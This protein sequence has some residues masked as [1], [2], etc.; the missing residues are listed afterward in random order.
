[1]R[2]LPRSTK[3]IGLALALLLL[4]PT[5]AWTA[6]AEDV[7]AIRPAEYMIYQ[8][9]GVSLVVKIDADEV[10]FESRITGPESALI[11]DSAVP[12]RR[13]GPMFQFIGSSDIPR[14]LM[15]KVT[16]G[17]RIDRSRIGMELIQLSGRDSNSQALAQAYELFSSGTERIHARDKGSWASKAYSLKGAA[18]AFAA[19]G[20]EEMRLWSEYYAAHLVLYRLN[21]VMTAIEFASGVRS[22]A[23]RA[24]FEKVE[25]A[26]LVL[27]G[28]ALMLA[29][30]TSP[31]ESSAQFRREVHTVFEALAG[32]AGKL[33][34]DSERGRALYNDGIAYE[35]EGNADKAI[36]RYQQ[37]LDVTL[38]T[39]DLD[40]ANEI[41]ATAAAAYETQ[42]QTSGAIE[43]L[44][45]IAGDL[46]D[47]EAP[48]EDR[49]AALVLAD[50][51]FEKGRLLNSNFRFHEA[52]K[53][54]SQALDIQKSSGAGAW[55]TTGL[56]LAWSQYASGQWDQ[57]AA[58][59]TESLSRTPR[60]G[61]AEALFRAYGSL[62]A[63]ARDRGFFG[64]ME[65]YR[66]LQGTLAQAG[67]L[68]ARHRFEQGIDAWIRDGARSSMALEKL[69]Q[70]RQVAA[71]AGA[72]IQQRRSSLHLCLLLL[73]RNGKG[74]CSGAE[75]RAAYEE[76]LLSGIPGLVLESRLVYSKIQL[77][78]GN[79][80]E[81]LVGLT[82]T[83]SEVRFYQSELRGVLGA[84]YWENKERLFRTYLSAVLNDSMGSA[85]ESSRGTPVLVALEQVRLIEDSESHR[86]DYGDSAQG[87]AYRSLLARRATATGQE[88]DQLASELNLLVSKQRQEFDSMESPL[89]QAGLAGLLAGLG[90][91]DSVLSYY[92]GEKSV[93][94]VLGKARGV[95]VL[96]IGGSGQ[97]LR[98]VATLREDL[99]SHTGPSA[100]E[101]LDELGETLLRPL[102]GAYTR[103]IFLLSAGPM[104][105]FP[106]DVLRLDGKYLA[107][108]HDVVMLRSLAS[109]A[110]GD[111]QLS[112]D[113]GTRVFL[114]GN[115]QARQDLFSYGVSSSAEILAVRDRFIG[116]GLHIVQG[117][118]LQRDEFRDERFS[119]ADLMH[120]AIPGVANLAFPER[121]RLSLSG[122][123]DES[124]DSYLRPAD[125]RTQ[126][127]SA[128]LAV[129]SNLAI[130]GESTSVFSNRLGFGSDLMDQGVRSVIISAWHVDDA[131]LA[132][133]M[134][135]FYANLQRSSDISAALKQTRLE[136]VSRGGDMK[137]RS[138]AGF[139]L[140][141]R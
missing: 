80:R 134:E 1:M 82:R 136:Q 126:E 67:E 12:Y 113:D 35:R 89:D 15:I 103:R 53:V 71:S 4:N 120:L 43:M 34:F 139:Q 88:A 59:V 51:L 45:D 75:G 101:S 92:F 13:I 64:Q 85:R 42:G 7:S 29:A 74:G 121:S 65:Q 106:F 23:R 118:A 107:W 128:R 104:T 132:A 38:T 133:F 138:W 36:Q 63:I 83:I 112:I 72:A 47:S 66:D 115:P 61:N 100:M 90:S 91:Q 94:A 31:D 6:Q 73:E 86:V 11:K 52:A 16:P 77:L 99:P 97:I 114:A 79:D 46:G 30:S 93:Y 125:L 26:S 122:S 49:D 116:P 109:L 131:E 37:A 39:D 98:Q 70:S 117:V 5:V 41:R 14:Q 81:A 95:R 40:L 124:A 57:A 127:Y 10:E 54:L 62:A 102:A 3:A 24:G 69:R 20:M 130:S 108:N 58:T 105:G 33:G 44:D 123:V 32:L 28:D 17:R 19:L 129:L 2:P 141:I 87:E 119:R 56:A 60:K 111:A 22:A 21:D 18:Q 137:F 27:Q 50:N 25:L 78:S 84:W 55:G 140:H 48:Q 76:L 68:R 8:Y 9:P 96:R 110:S 135:Q